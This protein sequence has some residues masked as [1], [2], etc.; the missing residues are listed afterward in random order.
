MQGPTNVRVPRAAAASDTDV[1]VAADGGLC[2]ADAEQI[3]AFLAYHGDMDTASINIASWNVRG[4]SDKATRDVIRELARVFDAV[5]LQ[6]LGQTTVS[7]LQS[8]ST[9]PDYYSD[10]YSGLH[11]FT[12]YATDRRNGVLTKLP[13]C[14]LHDG[15]EIDE[16]TATPLMAQRSCV[17][18]DSSVRLNKDGFQLLLSSFHTPGDSNN[19]TLRRSTYELNTIIDSIGWMQCNW[20]VVRMV[21][22]FAGDGNY[23]NLLAFDRDYLEGTACV[24]TPSCPTT[25]SRTADDTRRFPADLFFVGPRFAAVSR[26]HVSYEAYGSDH[27]F[28][29]VNIAA[30]RTAYYRADGKLEDPYVR[31]ATTDDR[32]GSG[33]SSHSTIVSSAEGAVV[34]ALAGCVAVLA[35]PVDGKDDTTPAEMM[36]TATPTV[37]SVVTPARSSHIST[38]Q[39]P[40]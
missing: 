23:Q 19:L 18:P 12:T 26:V 37:D 25:L 22:V 16:D 32:A 29:F 40:M 5:C 30:R 21:P 3:N 39:T 15:S 31:W 7:W 13:H 2:D 8:I 14:W 10:A 6:E 20:R 36:S 4:G 17:Y 34:D 33:D 11:F 1:S 9:P 35:F 24:H 27:R 28:I 38:P